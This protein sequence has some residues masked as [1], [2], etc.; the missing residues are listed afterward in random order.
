MKKLVVLVLIIFQ[1]KLATALTAYNC[2]NPH[3][4]NI[5]ENKAKDDCHISKK[6]HNKGEHKTGNLVQIPKYVEEVGFL[7]QVESRVVISYC[8]V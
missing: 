5:F 3:I 6:V 8:D 2:D 4:I 7:L 1:V